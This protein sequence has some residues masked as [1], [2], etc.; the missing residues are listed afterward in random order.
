MGVSI[1]LI[2]RLLWPSFFADVLDPRK[3]IEGTD[4]CREIMHHIQQFSKLTSKWSGYSSG[5]QVMRSVF[6]SVHCYS[7]YRSSFYSI[8]KWLSLF[9]E[10]SG[11]IVFSPENLLAHLPPNNLTPLALQDC[12]IAVVMD[13]MHTTQSMLFQSK[14]D[15]HKRYSR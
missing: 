5:E 9:K 11:L 2:N 10:S 13:R 3:E 14:L 1:P 12:A 6:T 15:F 8:S 7:H 4:V